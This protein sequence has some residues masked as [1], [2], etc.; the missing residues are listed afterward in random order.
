MTESV[1]ITPSYLQVCGFDAEFVEQFEATCPNG[2]RVTTGDCDELNRVY[3][4]GI[5]VAM[6]FSHIDTRYTG[7]ISDQKGNHRTYM[8]GKLHGLA[9]FAKADRDETRTYCCGKLHSFSDEPAVTMAYTETPDHGRYDNELHW[10]YESTPF[11]ERGPV[12]EYYLDG[13]LV[14][15]WYV[16]GDISCDA[17]L[18]DGRWRVSLVK[19]GSVYRESF[20]SLDGMDAYIN[21]NVYG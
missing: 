7:C 3:S 2:L 9:T 17:R 6:I 12:S 10:F 13:D 11:R 21:A 20:S 16:N 14:R 1:L 8:G 19:L 15:K 4:S 5:D 18:V